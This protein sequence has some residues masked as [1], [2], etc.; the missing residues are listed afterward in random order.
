MNGIHG[1]VLAIVIMFQIFLI[2]WLI[3]YKWFSVTGEMYIES[4]ETT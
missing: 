3:L 1:T 4:M 2:V